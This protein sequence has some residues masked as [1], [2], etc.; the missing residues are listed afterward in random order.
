MK[1][2]KE[3]V[4]QL[5]IPIGE[6]RLLASLL[7]DLKEI[8]DNSSKPEIYINWIDNHTEYSPERVDPCPDFYGMYT[9]KCEEVPEEIIGVEMDI[10]ELDTCLCCLNNYILYI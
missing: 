6:K 4:L 8:N 10:H 2:I 5:P 3:N 1:V 9:L 7:N